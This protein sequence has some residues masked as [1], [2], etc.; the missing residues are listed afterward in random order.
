MYLLKMGDTENK[1]LWDL[2]KDI[3][4]YVLRNESRLQQNTCQVA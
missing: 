4:D 1:K 2:A 3:W